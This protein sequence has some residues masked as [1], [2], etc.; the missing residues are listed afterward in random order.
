M[1]YSKT[2]MK[3]AENSE[4]GNR[5]PGVKSESSW[6]SEVRSSLKMDDK[7]LVRGAGV[8][9]WDPNVCTVSVPGPG[10]IVTD[11]GADSGARQVPAVPQLAF[12]V[13]ALRKAQETNGLDVLR[14]SE[15]WPKQQ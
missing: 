15:V 10:L 7:A 8:D 12:C 4:V 14:A 5:L 1:F 11:A 13:C 6:G 9:I 2:S 3:L